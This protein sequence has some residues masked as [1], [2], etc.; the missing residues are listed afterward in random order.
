MVNKFKVGDRIIAK[1]VVCVAMAD[2]LEGTLVEKSYFGGASWL[3]KFD[4]II[5]NDRDEQSDT[6]NVEEINMELANQSP[7][8]TI[9]QKGDKTVAVY[10]KGNNYFKS[11]NVKC[12]P[13]DTYD[14]S[15]GAALVIERLLGLKVADGINADWIVADGIKAEVKPFKKAKVGDR[16][17]VVKEGAMPH[18]PRVNIGQELIVTEVT[19]ELVRCTGDSNVFYDKFEEYIILEDVQ[20]VD[21]KL[22]QRVAK[23]G[24]YIKTVEK[25]AFGHFK[26]EEIYKVTKIDSKCVYVDGCIS[27]RHYEGSTFIGKIYIPTYSYVVLEEYTPTI[28]PKFDLSTISAEDFWNELQRRLGGALD[29][30]QK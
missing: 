14:F 2:G 23:V 13:D 3:V 1:K 10:K 20:T 16:I 11:A 7:S 6:W 4:K 19:D 26:T 24:E 21:Y 29:G 18:Y 8:I 30:M 5:K 9:T 25:S 17:K 22:I 15:I 28:E 27:D 12:G